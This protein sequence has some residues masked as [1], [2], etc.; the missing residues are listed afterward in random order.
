[1][2]CP[3]VSHGVTLMIK[4]ALFHVLFILFIKSH[5][6]ANGKTN[7]EC[8][9]LSNI[10]CYTLIKLV[11]LMCY[12]PGIG[13]KQKEFFPLSPSK[14]AKHVSI[15]QRTISKLTY[16]LSWSLV[17]GRVPLNFPQIVSFSLLLWNGDVQKSKPH[18]GTLEHPSMF[19]STPPFNAWSENVEFSHI[20]PLQQNWFLYACVL[21]AVSEACTFH[22]MYLKCLEAL[23]VPALGTNS[24]L[25]PR[26]W[27]RWVP[28]EW[29][30]DLN[31]S[32]D[33][34]DTRAKLSH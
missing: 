23:L 4:L 6:E 1:M 22:S 29:M 26:V 17:H 25:R 27:Q 8:T 9:L 7:N 20:H 3:V 24:N 14:Q 32:V 34:L 11:Q 10:V 31:F 15:W 28:I 30:Q 5:E 12:M 33:K 21:S 18:D 19:I 2:S 13:M 16:E